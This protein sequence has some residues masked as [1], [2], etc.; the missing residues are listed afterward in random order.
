MTNRLS[1]DKRYIVFNHQ[2]KIVRQWLKI[3]YR[4]DDWYP[5]YRWIE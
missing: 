1:D 3:R 2:P 4:G 5:I